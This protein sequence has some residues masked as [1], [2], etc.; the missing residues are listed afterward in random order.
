MI[1]VLGGDGTYLSIARLMRERSVPI[2]GVNMGQLGFLTEVRKEETIPV[3]NE[4]LKSKRLVI[5]ER[6]MLEV[7][8]IRKGKTIH[9]GL[10]V[11]DAVI[12]KGAIARIIELQN[13]NQWLDQFD[14]PIL[15][16]STPTDPR[17]TPGSGWADC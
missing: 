13:W 3:L 17:R 6:T 5:S 15:I 11:N 1:V 8:L 7:K 10:I 9:N 16:V 12:S 2:L 14:S 4:I